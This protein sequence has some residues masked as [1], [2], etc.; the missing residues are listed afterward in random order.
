MLSAYDSGE[1]LEALKAG[2]SGWQKWVKNFGKQLKRKGKSLFMP[3]RLLLTGKLHG[4]EMTG[5]IVLIYKAGICGAISPQAG[6]ITLEERFKMLREI[7]WEALH[8]EK[9]PGSDSV[10]ILSH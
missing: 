9:E 10:A 4:P 6:F 2:P 1:L 8:I 7:D 5:S 3:L